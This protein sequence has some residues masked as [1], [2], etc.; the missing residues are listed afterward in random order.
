MAVEV[1]VVWWQF[2]H[3]QDR[4][5]TLLLYWMNPVLLLRLPHQ[6]LLQAGD[7]FA[8][9]VDV[10]L[11]TGNN[12]WKITNQVNSILQAFLPSVNMQEDMCAN[13]CTEV[14][15]EGQG[16]RGCTLNLLN[17]PRGSTQS[18]SHREMSHG[19]RP[20]W[21]CV[22]YWCCRSAGCWCPLYICPWSHRSA[23]S[24]WR[25]CRSS[26]WRTGYTGAHW[27]CHGDPPGRTR[28]SPSHA[29][30]RCTLLSDVLKGQRESAHW[31][32]KQS[33]NY[34]HL[35]WNHIKTVH[36]ININTSRRRS[37]PGCIANTK[38][39][40]ESSIKT[41]IFMQVKLVKWMETLET[42]RD[43][44]DAAGFH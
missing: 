16:R 37:S 9:G 5:L 10:L 4:L 7:H 29:P 30:P 39:T 11:W 6:R 20:H 13:I 15:G 38:T 25:W 35:M 1:E 23:C 34:L 31:A 8:L 33:G 26:W 36:Q 17:W 43:T 18:V 2:C 32:L 19:Y 3:A 12:K 24:R 22:L 44:G 27:R 41:E 42:Y 14:T 28:G 21:P 40:S